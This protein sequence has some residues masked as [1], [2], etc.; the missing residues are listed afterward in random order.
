MNLYGSIL[1]TKSNFCGRDADSESFFSIWKPGLARLS[2]AP[3][4]SCAKGSQRKRLRAPMRASQPRTV[5]SAPPEKSLC[6]Q[7]SHQ[8]TLRA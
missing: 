5:P 4:S 6:S 2:G 8:V 1:A 3:P 7:R